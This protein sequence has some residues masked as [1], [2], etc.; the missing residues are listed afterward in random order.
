MPLVAFHGTA[1]PYLAYTG[2]YGPKVASL[3]T[4]DGKG[5]I[6]TAVL[7]TGDDAAPVPDMVAA[8]ATRGGCSAGAG[9]TTNAD[10]TIEQWTC[11]KGVDVALYTVDGGGHSWPGSKVSASAKD[12][13]G[14]TTMTISAN[15]LM[16]SFFQAHP[17]TS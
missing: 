9:P 14:P 13:V 10:I 8:W 7:A 2:G 15:A 11:P 16:W 4:P 1:D 12:L 5:T 3:P 6:G 17:L